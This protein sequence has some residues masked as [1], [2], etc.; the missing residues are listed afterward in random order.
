M[1]MPDYCPHLHTSTIENLMESY[2]KNQFDIH[3]SHNYIGVPADEYYYDTIKNNWFY[4]NQSCYE[5]F[6]NLR[7][8][9]E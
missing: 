4:N 7:I 8:K 6:Y 1:S 2:I 3:D 5:D 9:R